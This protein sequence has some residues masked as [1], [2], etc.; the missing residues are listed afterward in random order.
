MTYEEKVICDLSINVKN[1]N[2]KE[3]YG[4]LEAFKQFINTRE[5][6]SLNIKYSFYI[7]YLYNIE[8]RLNLFIK[9]LKRC[10]KDDVQ[11][12]FLNLNKAKF[13]TFV[14]YNLFKELEKTLD[15]KT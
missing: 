13:K 9:M 7:E 11:I 4:F 10:Q 8:K 15:D 12:N 3:L 1:Y 2:K 5:N 6:D 14:I